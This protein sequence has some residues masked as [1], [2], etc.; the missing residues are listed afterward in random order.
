MVTASSE[1]RWRGVAAVAAGALNI[2][3]GAASGAVAATY[4]DRCL[5]HLRVPLG[6]ALHGTAGHPHTLQVLHVYKL[7]NKL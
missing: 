5:H 2:G 1:W 7:L 4:H 6:L 3:L